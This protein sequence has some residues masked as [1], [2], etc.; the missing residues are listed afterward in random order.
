[1]DKNKMGV[2]ESHC[3]VLHGCKYCQD[4]DCPVEIGKT[5]QEFPC[6]RCYEDGIRSLEDIEKVQ[7]KEIKRCPYCSHVLEEDDEGEEQ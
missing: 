5:K 4:E 6:E 1:M 3:C 7:N 2:H